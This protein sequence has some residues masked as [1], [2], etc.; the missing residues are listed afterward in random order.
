MNL[1]VFLGTF[2]GTEKKMYLPHPPSPQPHPTT[3]ETH[4]QQHSG[5]EPALHQEG[6]IEV[7]EQEGV[8]AQP[9]QLQRHSQH[10][11]LPK[12]FHIKCRKKQILGGEN[13]DF[14]FLSE[15]FISFSSFEY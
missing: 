3:S 4:P 5:V 2:R 13:Y 14:F 1:Q 12:I 15:D 8:D 7:H 9:Y 6:H 11:T 10:I